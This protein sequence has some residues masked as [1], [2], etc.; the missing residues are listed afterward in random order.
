MI[1][2]L[3]ISRYRERETG[4][5]GFFGFVSAFQFDISNVH[6]STLF[7]H[8]LEEFNTRYYFHKSGLTP[9][10]PSLLP[11]TNIIMMHR[12]KTKTQTSVKYMDRLTLSRLG[13]LELDVIG[14]TCELLPSFCA[15]G[16]KQ[17]SVERRGG[18]HAHLEK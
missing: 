15:L 1:L 9:L 5:S 14:R 3:Q 13:K 16:C 17:T 18:I 10:S 8:S 2:C 7:F 11:P 6:S 4:V 12:K